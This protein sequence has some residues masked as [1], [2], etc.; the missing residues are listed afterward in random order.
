MD[1]GFVWLHDVHWGFTIAVYL[2]AATVSGGAYLAGLV[3]YAFADGAERQVRLAFVR[4]SFLVALVAVAIAGIAILSHLA[5]PL[6]G[7]LFPFTLTNFGSW[8]TRGTWILVSLGAFT[9]LQTLWFQ[10]GSPGTHGVGPSLFPR[11]IAGFLNIRETLDGLAESTRP[12]GHW[13][14]VVAAVGLLPAIGTVYTGFELSVVETV[15]LW[16]NPGV[17]PP[18]FIVSGVGAAVAIAL[19]LTVASE[20][21]TNRLTAVSGT[22]VAA[23]VLVSLGLVFVLWKSLDGSPAGIESKASLT[24]GALN[25][26]VM[27]LAASTILSLVGTPVLA[28]IGYLVEKSTGTNRALRLGLIVSLALGVVG[29]FLMREILLSAAVK[30]PIVVIGML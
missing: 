20:G 2:F 4:W 25:V 23:S 26:T 15:P 28:W 30:E 16:N 21:V 6:S 5:R 18:L 24:A 8:I 1:I 11:R 13:Y 9:A 27:A 19:M 3:A 10:F 7:L 22:V 14:W 29:T 17:I 12:T